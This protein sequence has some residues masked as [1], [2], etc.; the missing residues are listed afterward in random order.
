VG[1]LY[2]NFSFSRPLC[3]RLRPDV[4]TRHTDVRR[5]SSLNASALWE[6][7]IVDSAATSDTDNISCTEGFALPMAEQPLCC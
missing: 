5:A 6:R 1:Y 7:G 2:A 4:Y 3:S